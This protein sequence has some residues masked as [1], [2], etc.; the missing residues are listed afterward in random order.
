M[1][2]KTTIP[3]NTHQWEDR[4]KHP[5]T[6]ACPKKETEAQGGRKTPGRTPTCYAERAEDELGAV[7]DGKAAVFLLADG[8]GTF[9][10]LG[11]LPWAD[12][13]YFHDIH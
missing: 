1:G 2:F 12:F 3:P 10:I 11:V 6:R 13:L 7:Q 5:A 8:F 9:K 4:C